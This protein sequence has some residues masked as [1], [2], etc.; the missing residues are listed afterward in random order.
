MVG[1]AEAILPASSLCRSTALWPPDARQLHLCRRQ[2][3]LDELLAAAPATSRRETTSENRHFVV[4]EV[5]RLEPGLDAVA[6]AH[7]GD[8]ELGQLAA[9]LDR[10]RDRDRAAIS[11]AVDGRVVPGGD[12]DL[13][14]AGDRGAQ[15]RFGRAPRGPA[16]AARSARMTRLVPPNSCLAAAVTSAAVMPGSSACTSLRS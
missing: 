9:I 16:S 15:L 5:G 2:R 14:G 13:L 8:A 12:R 6:E 10:R 11:A 1:E 3:G 7:D 4:L